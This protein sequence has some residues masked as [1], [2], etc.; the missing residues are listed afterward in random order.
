MIRA[1]DAEIDGVSIGV[2]RLWSQIDDDR[3]I[4]V[5]K[6]PAGVSDWWPVDCESEIARQDL[7][8]QRIH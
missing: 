4:H 7:I 8:V 1:D 6:D 2:C 3:Q 5:R